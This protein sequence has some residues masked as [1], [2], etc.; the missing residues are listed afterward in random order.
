MDCC[1][2]EVLVPSS[3][4]DR[5]VHGK[6]LVRAADSRPGLQVAVVT[7]DLAKVFEAVERL[8]FGGVLA[9]EVPTWRA[10]PGPTGPTPPTCRP[11]W[12]SAAHPSSDSAR[13][14]RSQPSP[15]WSPIRPARRPA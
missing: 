13:W 15:G 5:R 11:G 7:R 9:N 8:D 2:L 4:A 1:R 14:R 10:A 12:C 6:G 3:G